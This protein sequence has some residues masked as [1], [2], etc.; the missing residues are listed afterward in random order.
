MNFHPWRRFLARMT[1]YL[2]LAVPLMLPLMLLLFYLLFYPIGEC[3]FF[4]LMRKLF[5]KWERHF[6]KLSLNHLYDVFEYRI[7]IMAPLLAILWLPVEAACLST[8]GATP[9]KWIFGIQVKKRDGERL[10]YGE[11][12]RRAFGTLMYGMAFGVPFLGLFTCAYSYH[13]LKKTGATAWDDGSAWSV[14][15]QP[16][17][18]P[19]AA[20]VVL[21]A[22][23]SMVVTFS[24]EEMIAGAYLETK[25]FWFDCL[26]GTVL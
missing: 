18:W 2:L 26:E 1:D 15:H 3:P 24:A 5:G 16:W 9:G 12:L 13:R 21:M 23:T 20:F 10:P 11:S 19:I 6:V 4:D 8:F 17:S 25:R 22:L 7:I 14:S